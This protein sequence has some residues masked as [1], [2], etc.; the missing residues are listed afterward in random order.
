MD[1]VKKCKTMMVME[2][3]YPPLLEAFD[4]RGKVLQ[5]LK[6]EF[7]NKI[8]HWKCEGVAVHFA[9]NFEK[10]TK[11]LLVDHLRSFI[12]YEDP[13]TEGEFKDDAIRFAKA[14]KKVFSTKFSNIDRLGVRYMSIFE[15][16]RFSSYNDALSIVMKKYFQEKLPISIKP[17]D[18]RATFV[19]ENGSLN[20]GPV[21]KDE[22]WVK[23]TFSL[24]ENNV[25]SFGLGVDIDS[26]ASNLEI[27]SSSNM[28]KSIGTVF[29]LTKAMELEVKNSLVGD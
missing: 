21:R 11:Q 23:Q 3:R 29:E 1:K 26:H 27:S 7:H 15:V 18:C 16:K 28:A 5:E 9:D 17:K 10:P 13:A 19:H 14:L 20:I 12:M 24:P 6:S 4:N 2:L 22:G 25:P 8:E